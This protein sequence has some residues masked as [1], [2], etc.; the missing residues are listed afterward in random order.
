MKKLIVAIMSAGVMVLVGVASADDDERGRRGPDV[1]PMT[2]PL[3]L[4]ECG[5]CHFAYQAGFLPARS[6]QKLMGG[7]AD[8]FG[9]NAE[10]NETDR[11]VIE[12]YLVANAADRVEGR[13]SN[14]F[15]RSIGDS[16][17]L[18]ISEVRYFRHEHDEIPQRVIKH[19][20]IGSFSNC[21]ACHTKADLGSYAER[22][23][24]IPGVGRWED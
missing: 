22:E 10:L 19:K 4:S 23:I 13:R 12:T 17:P 9:D 3:Y 1:K 20:N 5:S 14:K 11:E 24:R 6:W 15:M 2:N 7:L 8:H 16:T 21:I 18:R